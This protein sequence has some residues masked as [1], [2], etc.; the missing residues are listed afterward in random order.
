M[1]IASTA[2]PA[3]VIELAHPAY[4]GAIGGIY[5]TLWFAGNILV[6]WIA[7]ATIRLPGA[8]SWRIPVSCAFSSVAFSNSIFG[9]CS[10]PTS[11]SPLT[12]FWTQMVPAGIVLLGTFLIPESPRWLISRDRPEDARKIL[13][14]LHASGNPDSEL[15]ALEMEEMTNSI[16]LDGTDKRFWDY[17]GLVSTRAARY[18][19]LMVFFMA[20]FGQMSGS[21]MFSYFGATVLKAAGF[22]A[23]EE[24]Q[25]FIGIQTIVQFAT[26]Q[27]G[28][29]AVNK[30]GRRSLIIPGTVLFSVWLSVLAAASKF[31]GEF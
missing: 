9:I 19:M 5:N 6:T 23:A 4:R 26:S 31:A 15:V 24:R 18:R 11:P 7:Y 27:I 29:W 12:Q 10:F 2:A 13:I 28:V 22:S 14:D 20:F 3:Y 30:L 16:K 8:Q 17:S 21:N 25:L 1:T